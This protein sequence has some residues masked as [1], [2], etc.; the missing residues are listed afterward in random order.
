MDGWDEQFSKNIIEL[1]QEFYFKNS[2]LLAIVVVLPSDLNN[3]KSEDKT[4]VAKKI[5]A[6]KRTTRLTFFII[7]RL[8]RFG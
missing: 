6:I 7:S 1:H 3:S 8:G 4:L 5:K 2:Y